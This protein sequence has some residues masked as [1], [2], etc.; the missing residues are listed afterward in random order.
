MKARFYE[1]FFGL[2]PSSNQIYESSG[3]VLAVL[4]VGFGFARAPAAGSFND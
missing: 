4:E 1:V 3:L 2:L